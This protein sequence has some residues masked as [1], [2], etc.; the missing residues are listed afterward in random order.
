VN[1]CVCFENTITCEAFV[2]K[3]RVDGPLDAAVPGCVAEA[4]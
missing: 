1:V 4:M 2:V 3:S